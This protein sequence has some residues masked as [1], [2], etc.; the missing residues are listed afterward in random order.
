MKANHY[1]I[2][3]DG[4]FIGKPWVARQSHNSAGQLILLDDKCSIARAMVIYEAAKLHFETV[5]LFCGE[6]LGKSIE[7]HRA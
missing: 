2:I 3:A 5:D 6:D 7:S 1:T 4:E